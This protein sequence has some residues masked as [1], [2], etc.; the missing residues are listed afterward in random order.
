MDNSIDKFVLSA[1]SHSFLINVY[2]SC[3]TDRI[4]VFDKDIANTLIEHSLININIDEPNKTYHLTQEGKIYCEIEVEKEKIARKDNILKW[5]SL[6]L[7]TLAI[8]IS[9]LSL[10]IQID[11]HYNNIIETTNEITATAKDTTA[12]TITTGIGK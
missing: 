2:K 10:I 12:K 1:E 9:A 8:I 7:S 3:K 6:I 4:I 11:S 5:I